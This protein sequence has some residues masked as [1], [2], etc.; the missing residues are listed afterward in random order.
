MTNRL[1]IFEIEHDLAE[2]GFQTIALDGDDSYARPYVSLM[3]DPN[4][5]RDRWIAPGV[6]VDRPTLQQPD[7]FH[8]WGGLAFVLGTTV[9]ED[10]RETLR[11]SGELLPVMLDGVELEYLHVTHVCNVVDKS[12]TEW[13]DE[14]DET[15]DALAFFVHRLP[16]VPL[17]RV[18]E[19]NASQLFCSQGY[20][21]FD[22][23]SLVEARGLTGLLFREAWN[24]DAGPIRK[25]WRW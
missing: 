11:I 1:T 4:T 8:L 17:F 12:Q 9:P 13:D 23:K 3:A 7:F 5:V 19:N 2:N 18:P 10:V 20:G 22:F 14:E 25:V 24:T 6:C 15:S 16:A 21:E